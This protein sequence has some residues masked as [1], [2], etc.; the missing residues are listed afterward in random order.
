MKK[1]LMEHFLPM[2]AKE[3][4]L[5]DNRQLK[6]K[7]R[8]LEYENACLKAYIRGMQNGIRAGRKIHT[9]KGGSQ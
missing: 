9:E 1:W 8:A 6:S 5:S 4:V 7:L 2:W 3:T